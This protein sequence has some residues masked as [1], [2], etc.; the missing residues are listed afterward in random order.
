MDLIT[1]ENNKKTCLGYDLN[2]CN[3]LV[4]DKNNKTLSIIDDIFIAVELFRILSE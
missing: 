1:L 2:N 3:Y 4:F